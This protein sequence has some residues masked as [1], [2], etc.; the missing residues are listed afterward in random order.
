[1][2]DAGGAVL[3]AGPDVQLVVITGWVVVRSH[4]SYYDYMPHLGSRQNLVAAVGH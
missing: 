4:F 1:M 2:A 3:G